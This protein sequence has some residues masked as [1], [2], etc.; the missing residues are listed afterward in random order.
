MERTLA[1]C[2][3]IHPTNQIF[4]STFRVK[5]N[6]VPSA[7]KDQPILF[8]CVLIQWD[9]QH[10]QKV[11]YKMPHPGDAWKEAKRNIAMET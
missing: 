5:K 3:L 6:V 8:Q 4:I 10:S 2:F 1:S 7:T 11:N 9:K